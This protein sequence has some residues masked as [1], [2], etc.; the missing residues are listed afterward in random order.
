MYSHFSTH[1]YPREKS[2]TFNKVKEP[3]GELSN[4]YS[5]TPIYVNGICI[6]TTEALYQASRFPEYPSIQE[7][8]LSTSNPMAVKLKSRQYIKYTRY[9]WD[10]KKVEIMSWCVQL[11]LFQNANQLRPL[12]NSTK[13]KI[14]VEE[15]T[16]DDFWGAKPY[17]DNLIGCNVLGRIWMKLRSKKSDETPS[18]YIPNF[19]LYEQQ[20]IPSTPDTTQQL[21]LDLL[22]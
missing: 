7:E 22:T 14:L 16:K 21:S 10:I 13:G 17:Q 5:G 2:I 11:K 8:L 1:I 19:H 20:I 6:A 18:L 4:M 3:L 12:L 15:S 9:D